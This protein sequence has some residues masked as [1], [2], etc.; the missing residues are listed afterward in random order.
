[1]SVD[2]FNDQATEPGLVKWVIRM[3]GTG[4]SVPTKTFGRG[5]TL[6]RASTGLVTLTWAEAPGV[7]LGITGHC[8]E[9]NTQ[10]ALKGYSVV[11]GAFAS[12]ALTLNITDST[13]TLADLAANQFLT[14]TVSFKRVNA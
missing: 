1:M 6:T 2:S 11:G 9:A 13:N 4:A 8:F 7:Y 10:S 14:L 12:N 3:T 5:V